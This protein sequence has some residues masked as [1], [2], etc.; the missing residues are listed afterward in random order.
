MKFGLIFNGKLGY[1]NFGRRV[2][3]ELG[4]RRLDCDRLPLDFDG[5]CAIGLNGSYKK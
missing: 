3:I 4:K 1:A 2:V 5:S